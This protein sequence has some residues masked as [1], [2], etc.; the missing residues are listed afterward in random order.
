MSDPPKS[1]GISVRFNDPRLRRPAKH[2]RPDAVEDARVRAALKQA[3]AHRGPGRHRLSI[4]RIHDE[5]VS[6]NLRW[7]VKSL[8]GVDFVDCDLA[9]TRIDGG[10]FSR[11]AIEDCTFE[12]VRLDPFD[13]SKLDIAGF[14][15]DR[16]NFASRIDATLSDS[17]ITRGVFERC[18]L[19]YLEFEHCSLREVT[20]DRP[21]MNRTAFKRSDLKDVRFVGR[22]GFA[23][24]IDSSLDRV[25]FSEANPDGV[26]FSGAELV[27]IRFPRRPSSFVV[28]HAQFNRV[29]SQL[30]SEVSARSRRLME[31]YAEGSD[32]SVSE[33]FFVGREFLSGFKDPEDQRLIVEALFPHAIA[34]IGR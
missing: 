27:A 24:F 23:F 29:A 26:Q 15:L 12:R 1:V 22:M 28:T 10:W 17:T 25:D 16:V 9:G 33:P 21:R 5:L 18:D 8:R 20:F 2:P 31:V 3:G 11:I 4:S 7:P 19:R 34:E 32:V 6:R 30:V 14:H 13:G